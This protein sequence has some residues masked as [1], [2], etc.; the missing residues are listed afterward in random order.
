MLSAFDGGCVVAIFPKGPFPVFA[1][2]VFLCGS[3]GDQ[4]DSLGNN[5]LSTV[6]FQN[7]VDMI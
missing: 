3:S 7:Q 5:P 6:I 2:V 4:A 1:L